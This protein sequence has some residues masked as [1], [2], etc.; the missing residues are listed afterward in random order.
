MAMNCASERSRQKSTK[1][2]PKAGHE[3]AYRLVATVGRPFLAARDDRFE[4]Y[5]IYPDDAPM[6]H[7]PKSLE[8]RARA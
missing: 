8:T 7:F 3:A 6:G 5:D 2:D 1:T 4:E